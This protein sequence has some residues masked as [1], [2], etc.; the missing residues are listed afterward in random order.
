MSRLKGFKQS[1]ETKNKIGIGN[2]G[3][4]SFW[5]GKKLCRETKIKMSESKK[6]ER[7]PNW[8]NGKSEHT[9]GY[10]LIFQPDHPFANFY[11]YVFEHRL[12]MEKHLGRYLKP[13][14][15]VH[16][17][18]TKYPMGSIEDKQDNRIE[19]LKLFVNNSGHLKYHH[20][21]NKVN[22]EILQTVS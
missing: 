20:F 15:I 11:G 1:E 19:N 14:E 21:L 12:V 5:K 8:K 6:R 4:P 18:G 16:H 13:E 7:N 3:K 22:N 9:A 17:N 10:I 2:K